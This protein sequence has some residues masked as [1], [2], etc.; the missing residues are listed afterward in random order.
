MPVTDVLSY[1]SF[2][3]RVTMSFQATDDFMAYVQIANGTKPGGFNT[4]YYRSDIFS[5]YTEYLRDCDPANPD[6]PP[7]TT[8]PLDP[9]P[10]CTE[11]EK[12]NL[13]IK[14]EEQWTYEAGF[15]STWLD[16]RITAN[17]SVFYIDWTNQ[18]MF[19]RAELPNSSGTTNTTT[20]LINAGKSKIVGLELE[21]NFAATDN[22]LLFANYGFNDG[23]FT[24]GTDSDLILL[25]G[26][27]GDLTGHTIPNSP[28]HSVIF[29]FDA[30]APISAGLE[31]FLR[32]DFLY[33]SE[34]FTS[35]SN[36]GTLGERKI[37]NLHA[38]LRSDNWTLTFYV[39]N[40]TDDETPLSVFNF[41]NF[42]VDE[43][44]TP[45]YPDGR[46]AENNGEF[47]NMYAL[48]PQR[49]RDI[50]M[51]FQWRFGD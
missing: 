2:T 39:R 48:N 5:E 38:G 28:Q 22:L 50:G 51:E 21:S 23:E 40:L 9:P 17:L 36:F 47:P 12:G 6:L 29:G 30:T 44:V 11:E 3:P 20:I 4:E 16:R 1:T 27:D 7:A 31:G 24:E 37:V 18:S 41:V 10:E 42:A 19:A 34:H 49:G 26:G 35:S 25:T 46:E 43:I 15:K 45:D 33:E 32:S 14:E 13:Y 8:P